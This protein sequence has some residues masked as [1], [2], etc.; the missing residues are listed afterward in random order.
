MIK[1]HQMNK[2]ERDYRAQKIAERKLQDGLQVWPDAGA[3][4]KRGQNKSG[5]YW[6][7]PCSVVVTA[8]EIEEFKNNP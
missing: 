8:K 2:P 4:A 5:Y 7:V 3:K 1:A 6:T